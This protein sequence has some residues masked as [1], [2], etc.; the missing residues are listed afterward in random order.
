MSGQYASYWNAFLFWS[1]F[2]ENCIKLEKKSNQEWNRVSD[3][4][5]FYFNNASIG[6]HF[7]I[8]QYKSGYFGYITS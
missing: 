2:P 5:L 8:L 1:F 3:A 6:T 4:P 7:F